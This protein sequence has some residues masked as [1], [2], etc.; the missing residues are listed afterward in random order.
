MERFVASHLGTFFFHRPLYDDGTWV[1]AEL[2][3]G[4]LLDDERWWRDL[5]H[6]KPPAD[7]CTR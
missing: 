7:P 3:Y 6:N 4:V 1:P 5:F 2:E